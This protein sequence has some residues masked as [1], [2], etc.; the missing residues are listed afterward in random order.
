MPVQANISFCM[1][2][3]YWDNCKHYLPYLDYSGGGLN[4]THSSFF[5]HAGMHSLGAAVSVLPLGT[6]HSRI[7]LKAGIYIPEQLFCSHNVC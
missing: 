7:L 1:S 2:G 6:A 5:R 4:Y 3:E